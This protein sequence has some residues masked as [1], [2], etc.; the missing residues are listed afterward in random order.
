MTS[1]ASNLITRKKIKSDAKAVLSNRDVLLKLIFCGLFYISI[2]IM[3]ELFRSYAFSAAFYKTVDERELQV[4]SFIFDTVCTIPYILLIYPLFIGLWKVAAG[5][6]NDNSV[7]FIDIFTYYSS[8]KKIKKAWALALILHLP[9]AIINALFNLISLIQT[10][11]ISIRLSLWGISLI[12]SVVYFFT[13][14]FITA[15]LFPFINAVV[16]GADQP[17][18]LCLNAS[19]KATSG[20]MWKLWAF[21]LSFIPWIF[22]S[23][24]TAGVLFI[25]FTFPYMLIAE[26]IYSKYLLTGEYRDHIKEETL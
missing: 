11:K 20:K 18:S 26:C 23:L 7:E 5:L 15:R 1:D 13:S 21:P 8:F 14:V 19:L 2:E 16:C 12:L 17:I 4:Y 3:F 25:I 24:L 9:L 10:D 22:L 6:S